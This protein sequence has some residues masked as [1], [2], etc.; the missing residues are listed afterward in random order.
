M[1]RTSSLVTVGMVAA[2]SLMAPAAVA[3]EMDAP[4]PGGPGMP[5]SPADRAMM[6]GMGR[7]KQQM[8]AAPMSGDADH[9]FIAMMTPHH[10]GAID[11]A[12]VE[13]RYGKDPELLRLA[14]DIVHAQEREIVQMNAWAAAHPG[15]VQAAE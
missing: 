1:E 9:D 4:T 10:A 11:M 14:H 5:R 7:M 8:Q 3:G 2:L 13:L 12:K 6:A 15:P